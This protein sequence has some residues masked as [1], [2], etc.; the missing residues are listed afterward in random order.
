MTL[1]R[2]IIFCN[3]RR[4]VDWLTKKMRDRDF[5]VSCIYGNMH[6]QELDVIVREFDTGSSRVL[7]TA[8][9]NAHGWW[10]L[11]AA[12]AFSPLYPRTFTR[13]LLSPLAADVMRRRSCLEIQL[14]L[15]C[16]TRRMVGFQQHLWPPPP[17]TAGKALLSFGRACTPSHIP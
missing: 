1:P 15:D 14:T 11:S 17:P 9:L 6:K 5:T 4:K 3:T 2:A 16:A 8:D 13:R 12:P 7:I 10:T